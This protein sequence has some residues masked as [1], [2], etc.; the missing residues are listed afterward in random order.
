MID[1]PRVLE[2]VSPL[3]ESAEYRVEGLAKVT[4]EAQYAADVTRPG[5]LW[6][7]FRRSDLPHAD[8]KSVV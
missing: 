7:G 6:A 2:P 5:M 1:E 8:R 4:G 3:L